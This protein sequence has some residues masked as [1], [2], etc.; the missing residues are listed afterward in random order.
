[1]KMTETTE[2]ENDTATYKPD[3]CYR[4]GGQMGL[5]SLKDTWK[6][7]VDGV[8][9]AVPVHSVPCLRCLNCNTTVLNG[10]SDEYVVWCLNKY[11]DQRGLN[12]RW[13]KVRRW[14]RRRL[15]CYRDRWDFWV[16]KTFYKGKENGDAA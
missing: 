15:L 7:N 12:T 10:W 5:F 9:H 2:K 14:V 4:C 6:M 3:L 11:L 16:Y 1:M 8:L 13:H